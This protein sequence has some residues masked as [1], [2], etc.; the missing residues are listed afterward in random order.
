MK[1]QKESLLAL[2]VLAAAS[3]LAGCSA[4]SE[5]DDASATEVPELRQIPPTGLSLDALK[6]RVTQ[7]ASANTTKTDAASLADTRRALNPFVADLA[8]I[9]KTPAVSV[10]LD[11]GFASTW[12]QLFSDDVRPAPPGAP[13]QDP[14][15]IHQV[16]T[17]KAHHDDWSARRRRNDLVWLPTNSTLRS[18][19]SVSF[20]VCC[21]PARPSV[22][23]PRASSAVRWERLVQGGPR[24]VRRPRPAPVRRALA[25]RL[26][27][28]PEDRLV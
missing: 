24:Q 1:A 17:A 20:R 5:G 28:R 15:S 10:E 27:A 18:R 23:S 14:A 2:L 8:R 11:N 4:A 16:V 25:G 3:A 22:R 26:L 6:A 13:T 12:K 7:I 21:P 9:Y 19:A